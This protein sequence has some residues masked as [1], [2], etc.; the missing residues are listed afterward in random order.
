MTQGLALGITVGSSNTVAVTTSG[1]GG[2]LRD[3]AAHV[4]PSAPGTTDLLSRVGD[5]VAILTDDGTSIAAADLVAELVSHTVNTTGPSAAMLAHPA[6]W[7]RHTAAAQRAALD[8]ADLSEVALVSEPVAAV[9]WLETARGPIDAAAVLVYDLG[10]T[11]VTVSAVGTGP[12][13]GLLAEPLRSTEIGG[14]EF[15]L[16]T[17]RYVLANVQGENDFDPFDPMVERELAA[18]RQRCGKAKEELSGITATVVPVRLS[19]TARD[20]RLVRDELE[21][22]LREPLL[23]SLE[24]IHQAARRAGLGAIEKILLTGGGAAIPLLT[25]LVST[26]FGVA[27]VSAAEPAHT[28]ASGA[29]LLAAEQSTAALDTVAEPELPAAPTDAIPAL[30]HRLPEPDR[31]PVLPPLPQSPRPERRGAWRR[32]AFIGGAAVAVAAL[33]TGTLALGTAVQTSQTSNSSPSPAISATDAPTSAPGV[34][35]PVADNGSAPGGRTRTAASV[36]AKSTTAPAA[37]GTSA[38][39]AAEQP[40]PAA[41]APAAPEPNAAAPQPNPAPAPPPAPSAPTVQPPTVQQP[42]PPTAPSRPLPD[43]GGTLNDGLGQAGN[44]LGTVLQAPGQVL[45]HTGG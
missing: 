2:D 13:G 5:P 21:D 4:R 30:R 36:G 42:S 31:S 23:G 26:E 1:G 18:L 41:G 14:A 6:W 28:A 3:A 37:P 24:L 43:I 12:C 29:A 19:G 32:V 44:T 27:V 34:A 38:T 20:V 10:T 45:G 33:A 40:A 8:R 39:P 11:G 15:D 17:M 35:A 16:L 25:E 7:S 9:R 22:L